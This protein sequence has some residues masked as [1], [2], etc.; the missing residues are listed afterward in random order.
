MWAGDMCPPEGSVGIKVNTYKTVSYYT[1]RQFM[2]F[3]VT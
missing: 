2:T 3:S 1:F